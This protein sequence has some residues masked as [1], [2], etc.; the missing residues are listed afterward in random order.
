MIRKLLNS[1]IINTSVILARISKKKL[2]QVKKM[3]NCWLRPTDNHPDNRANCQFEILSRSSF[4][5]F[6]VPPFSCTKRLFLLRASKTKNIFEAVFF[7]YRFQRI[8]W[9]S[10]L[11][12]VGAN[13]TWTVVK[14][15]RQKYDNESVAISFRD[16][17]SSSVLGLVYAISLIIS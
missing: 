8:F 14:S 4:V 10:S 1:R 9:T 15:N 2:S 13:W 12:C 5:F 6:L 11:A 17:A 16:G 7:T 3:I